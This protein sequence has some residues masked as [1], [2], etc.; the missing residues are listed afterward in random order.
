MRSQPLNIAIIGGGAVGSVLGRV[1]VENKQRITA[2]VSRS[3]ASARRCGRFLSC[4]TVS[5][6][7]DVIPQNTQVIMITAPH[8]AIPEVARGLSLRNGFKWKGVSV[9][10]ASGMLTADALAPLRDAGATVFSFHPIQTFPRDFPPRKI[11]PSARGIVYGVD[12]SPAGIRM[13]RK[14]ARA[15]EGRI[16]LVPPAM[17]EFYH[18]ACVVASNHLVTML[19]ILRAFY[20]DIAPD[21]KDFIETFLPI[22]QATLTNVRASSPAAA[23]TGPVARGGTDTIAR[24]L[25]AIKQQ[26]PALVPYYAQMTL[27]TIRLAMDKK[28]LTSTQVE[29]LT[30]LAV[31]YQNQPYDIEERH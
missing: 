7:L 9:C 17:R 14:L 23:L 8:G 3:D 26:I 4:R 5:T 29:E 20:L 15:L 18:A 22:I 13:A 16:I 12:G 11:V 24:H 19:G 25:A 1:L 10:H 21:R 28:T 31:S 27:E 2:V 6:S 30:A